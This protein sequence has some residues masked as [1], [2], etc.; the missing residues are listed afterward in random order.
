MTSRLTMT[1]VGDRI[2]QPGYSTRDGSGRLVSGENGY[3]TKRVAAPE[4]SAEQQAKLDEDIF[5]HDIIVWGGICHKCLG[6]AVHYVMRGKRLYVD[7][8]FIRRRE[9]SS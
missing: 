3:L 6:W 7:V 2:D 5:F 8:Y 1:S 4:P 9:I